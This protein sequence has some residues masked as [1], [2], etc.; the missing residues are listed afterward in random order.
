MY[1]KSKNKLNEN[2]KTLTA[3]IC[4]YY[5]YLLFRLYETKADLVRKYVAEISVNLLYQVLE[6]QV[7]ESLLYST[8]YMFVAEKIVIY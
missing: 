2:N 6:Y 8:Y 3:K 1:N 5:Y 4:N 7:I